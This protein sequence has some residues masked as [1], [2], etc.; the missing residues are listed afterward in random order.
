MDVVGTLVS[1]FLD[2][3]GKRDASLFPHLS[4]F[5]KKLS[6]SKLST[7]LQWCCIELLLLFV[8]RIVT[9]LQHLSIWQYFHNI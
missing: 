1:D 8:F 5:A 2:N 4:K 6:D 7:E 9:M 3:C